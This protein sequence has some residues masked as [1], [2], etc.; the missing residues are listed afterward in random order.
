MKVTIVEVSPRDG[1]QNEK[2]ILT[3]AQK[4]ELIERLIG[5]GLTRIEALSFASPKT[6]PTMADAEALSNLLPRA[7]EVRYAGLV[8]NPKGL[9]RALKIDLDEINVVVCVSDTFSLRNQGVTTEVAMSNARSIIATARSHGRF[10]TLTL[11]V[12]FGCPFEGEVNPER[13]IDLALKAASEGVDEICIA[14]T[15]GVGVPSHV[16]NFIKSLQGE[17]LRTQTSLRFHFHNTRNTGIANALV[18]VEGGVEALDA[19]AGGIGGCPFAPKATGNIATDD[20]A[21]M[22]ERMG[23]DTGVCLPK[24]I[25]IAGYLTSSLGHEVPALLPRA[26]LFPRSGDEEA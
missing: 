6:V 26:G 10:T 19:S 7:G 17:L 18:A 23:I 24:L 9:D 3:T 13:V 2:V 16:R 4:L 14:D 8:L 25:P 20:I 22:L 12:A 5:A 1:L 15:I 11:A 21:F